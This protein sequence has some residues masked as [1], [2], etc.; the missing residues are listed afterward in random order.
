MD[1]GTEKL[2]SLHTEILKKLEE[3]LQVLS[4]KLK[5]NLAFPG[6]H[7]FNVLFDFRSPHSTVDSVFSF[8]PSHERV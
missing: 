1:K 7:Q 3:R 5:T 6:C 2:Q 4:I 8:L